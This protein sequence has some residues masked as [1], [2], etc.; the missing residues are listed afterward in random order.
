MAVL[1][2]NALRSQLRN[3]NVNEFA[4][5]KNVIITPSARQYLN[6][7]NIKLVIKEDKSNHINVAENVKDKGDRIIPKYE[8]IY[9]GFYEKK[10]ETMTQIYGNKLVYKDHPRII[11]RGKMDTLQ[12]EILQAQILA[13][14]N[15]HKKILKELDEILKATREIM[16]AEVLNE[17]LDELSLLGMNEDELRIVSHNPKK[18]F[19]I[20]HIFYANYEMG[21]MFVSINKLRTS[22]REVEISAL[23]AFKNVEGEVSRPDI[24]KYL[25]RLSSCFYIIMCKIV[26]GQYSK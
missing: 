4:I 17:K 15:G 6:D 2:E 14:N 3:C 20:D 8:S 24:I 12:A 1:T 18:Y 16:K 13:K 10:P 19:G 21:E 25:N 23:K 9:G 22:V 11:F 5:D 7:R 26:S